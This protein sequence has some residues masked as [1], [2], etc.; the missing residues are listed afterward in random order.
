MDRLTLQQELERI[1]EEICKLPHNS[2]AFWVSYLAHQ[3]E[4]RTRKP[5]LLLYQP[6]RYP[7]PE[8]VN[9]EFMESVV[10]ALGYRPYPNERPR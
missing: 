8:V 7:L 6:E 9:E 1:A 3:V 5:D 4:R 10:K 2:R